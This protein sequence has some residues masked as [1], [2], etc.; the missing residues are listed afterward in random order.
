MTAYFFSASGY[1][2]MLKAIIQS[3]PMYARTLFNS[4][5]LCLMRSIAFALGFGKVGQ[6]IPLWFFLMEEFDV[7]GGLIVT[8]C[9]HDLG[10]FTPIDAYAILNILLASSRQ[11]GVLICHH[12]SSSSFL[13]MSGYFLGL[14]FVIRILNAQYNSHRLIQQE[15]NK[16]EYIQHEK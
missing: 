10:C 3:I 7:G 12:E 6:R 9:C 8:E 4:F 15:N 11:D 16:G 13:V 2:F 1:E 5:I 14:S